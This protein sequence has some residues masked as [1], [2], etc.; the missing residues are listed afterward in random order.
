MEFANPE[1]DSKHSHL[2]PLRRSD[3]AASLFCFPGSGGEIFVFDD[4]AKVIRS[5]LS[6]YAINMS[7]LYE[8]RSDFTVQKIGEYYF[9]V[10]RAQQKRGPY[11]LC[12]YSFGGLVTYEIAAML[13]KIGEE[14][15]LVALLDAPCPTLVSNLSPAEATRFRATYVSDRL[16]K[17]GS[18]LLS[19]NFSKL[20]GDAV[21]FMSQRAGAIPWLFMRSAFRLLRMPLPQTLQNNNPIVVEAYK[22]Y[23]PGPYAGRLVLFRSESRGREH[24]LDPNFGW[25]VSATGGID[26]HVVPGHHT[27][28]MGLPNVTVVAEIMSRYLEADPVR[29]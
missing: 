8:A 27:D 11:Y 29:E 25:G 1:P 13:A 17:Y 9:G 16:K 19:G 18:N 5:N 7:E 28:M 26:S 24:N 22:S 10:V 3:T 4:L 23:V 20:M 21:A 2:V 14:V 15:G 6:I 12:G